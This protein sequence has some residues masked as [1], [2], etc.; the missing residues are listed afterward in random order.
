MGTLAAAVHVLALV[1]VLVH[2]H[3]FLHMGGWS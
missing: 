3:Y 1:Q 2:L